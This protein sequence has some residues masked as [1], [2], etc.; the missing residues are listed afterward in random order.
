MQRERQKERGGIPHGARKEQSRRWIRRG[1]AAGTESDSTPLTK[2]S[3]WW[4]VIES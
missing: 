2:T 1:S 4:P 3:T